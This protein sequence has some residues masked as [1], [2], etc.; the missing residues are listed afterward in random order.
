LQLTN[1]LAAYNLSWMTDGV[2]VLVVGAGEDHAADGA[3]AQD[4]RE[5]G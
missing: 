2:V 4:D 5:L 1:N 3:R